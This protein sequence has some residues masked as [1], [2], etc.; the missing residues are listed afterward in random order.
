MSY[1]DRAA[2]PAFVDLVLSGRSWNHEDVEACYSALRNGE[3]TFEIPLKQCDVLV[4][5]T[6]GNP[7]AGYRLARCIR[8]FAKSVSFLVPKYAYSAGTLLCF[9]GDE[10]VLGHCA[11]LSPIDITY[12]EEGQSGQSEVQLASIDAFLDFSDACQRHIQKVLAAA[13][14]TAASSV[15]SDVLCQMVEQVGA[16]KV[17]QYYRART[18]TGHYAQE[19]LERYMLSG[20]PNGQGIAGRIVHDLL[21]AKPVHEFHLDYSLC[22]QLGLVVREMGSN[23]SDAARMV[24]EV[25]DRLA[26]GGRICPPIDNTIRLPFI[27]FFPVTKPAG[28]TT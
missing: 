25:L 23:E 11:G 21:F 13:G 22:E 28:G 24:I 12:V 9:S 20:V 3:V 8:G 4:H 27:A 17:G 18:L 6:G 14:V 5:T 10:I 16:L 26:V 15:G 7:V 2:E 19:L 1:A